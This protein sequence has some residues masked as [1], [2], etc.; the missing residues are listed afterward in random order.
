MNGWFA[1]DT[2]AAPG[3]VA[4]V[5][6]VVGPDGA[7]AFF[8]RACMRPV[9]VGA[10][11]VRPVFGLDHALVARP[12]ER[13]VLIMPHGG[14]AIVRGIAGAMKKLGMSRV[15]HGGAFP[16]G[17]DAVT[18]RMLETLA[19]AA[20]PLGVDLLLDQPRRWAA[21][22]PGDRLAEA[23]TLGRLIDPPVVVAVGAANIGKSSLLNA[24][25]GASVALAFDRAGTTR[26]AVGV[27]VDLGGLVVR[28]VDT[29]GIGAGS[30][31]ESDR[32][33]VE[34]GEADLIVRC[35]DAASP[36]PVGPGEG[37]G[38]VTVATRADRGA[39]GFAADA[40]TSATSGVGLDG[41]VAVVR[42][43][44]VPGAAMA[45]PAPWRFWHD[46]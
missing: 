2:P 5:R 21:W 3:A 6:V 18:V 34:A 7:E 30:G 38:S 31:G 36:G 28:W 35:A 24:L 45:D 12:D 23:T 46:D 4:V 15:D 20:S 17:A 44:L 29:P 22:R 25:A 16:E 19:R 43:R 9:A 26:D 11:A 8:E 10:S 37:A 41:L 42:E 40:L 13:T 27:L 33:W 32:V 39:P 14:Q 1:I